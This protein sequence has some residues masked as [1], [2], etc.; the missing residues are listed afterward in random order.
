MQQEEKRLVLENYCSRG[1]RQSAAP[2]RAASSG[3]SGAQRSASGAAKPGFAFAGVTPPAPAAVV[4]P[5]RAVE[6]PAAAARACRARLFTLQSA[7][8]RRCMSPPN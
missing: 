6:S 3:S 8:A 7:Y 5:R 1:A 4:L 2:L